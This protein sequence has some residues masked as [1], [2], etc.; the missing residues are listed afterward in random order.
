MKLAMSQ[1]GN[2]IRLCVNEFEIVFV[3]LYLQ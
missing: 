3:Y 1:A 2:F